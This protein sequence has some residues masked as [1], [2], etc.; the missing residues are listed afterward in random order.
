MVTLR[1][2]H[3]PDAWP[4]TWVMKSVRLFKKDSQ[5]AL[6]IPKEELTQFQEQPSVLR[7]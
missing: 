1:F 7:F 3:L 5:M 2:N 4:Q 6:V